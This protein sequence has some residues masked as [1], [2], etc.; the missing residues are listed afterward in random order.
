MHDSRSIA[1]KQ[2]AE[3]QIA[4]P[5]TDRRS[6]MS[7]PYWCN[8]LKLSGGPG[9]SDLW[10]VADGSLSL[11]LFLLLHNQVTQV[12]DND[13]LALHALLL[14]CQRHGAFL[15][16]TIDLVL[17]AQTHS[18]YIYNVCM[19]VCM[20]VHACVCVCVCVVRLSLSVTLQTRSVQLPS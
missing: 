1:R 15:I 8:N 3:M 5:E 16:C 4:D 11:L 17:F 6:H 20:Y 14:V 10:G 2:A 13:V 19:Y 18:L 7:A 12:A 9:A